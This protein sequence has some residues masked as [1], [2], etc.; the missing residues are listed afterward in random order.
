MYVDWLQFSWRFQSAI[1]DW[2]TDVHSTHTVI[3][4]AVVTAASISMA[5]AEDRA[6]TAVV[7]ICS[8]LAI[9]EFSQSP[10]QGM[11]TTAVVLISPLSTTVEVTRGNSVATRERCDECME[12]LVLGG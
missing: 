9:V 3:V 1:C 11:V 10:T 5:P 2:T 7:L 6:A 8:F 4:M 12:R